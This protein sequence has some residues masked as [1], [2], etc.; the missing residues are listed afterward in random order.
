MQPAHLSRYTLSQQ[1]DLNLVRLYLQVSTLSEL[2]DE[3]NPSRIDLSYLDG[4]RSS[5]WI[6]S[7]RWPRQQQPTASQRRLWKRYLSSSYLRYIPYWRDVPSCSSVTSIVESS[8]SAPTSFST[9][10]EYITTLPRTQRRLL[11]DVEQSATDLQIWRAFRSKAKLYVASDGGLHDDRGT[12]GWILS[13][14]KHVLFRGAGPIDGPF[15][16]SSSTRSELGGCASSLLLIVVV[17]RLWGLRHRCK[18]CWFTDSKAAISRTNR[19]SRKKRATRM[20]YDADLLS[21]ISDLLAELRRPIV[22]V[23]VKGHQDSLRAYEKL[24]LAARLNIDADFLATRYRLRGRLKSSEQVDHSHGQQVSIS[25]NGK[26]LTGQFDECIRHHING[27]H[28]RQYTQEKHGWDNSTWNE[29]DFNVFARHYQR[30]RP[31]RQIQQMKLIHEQLP[32]GK[33]RY[34]QATIKDPILRLCPCCREMEEDTCHLLKCPSNP[35]HSSGLLKLGKDLHD[36]TDVHPIRHII[37]EGIRHWASG[38]PNP[39]NIDVQQFPLHM[40]ACI[41]LALESQNRIGWYPAMMGYYSR[42][43]FQVATR[44]VYNYDSND[45]QR[46]ASRMHECI[47]AVY[48]YTSSIWLSRNEILHSK[49]VDQMALIRSEEL[50]E[51]RFYHEHSHLL[52]FCDRHYCTRSLQRLLDGPP[53]TRRRWLRRV[54]KS[55]TAHQRD[56]ERQTYIPSFFRPAT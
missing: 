23:W 19:Y 46:G 48:S 52:R 12:F 2:T 26:R 49:T 27:Y 24:P 22:S 39:L 13:T 11:A 33:R 42:L 32:V 36:S 25:I 30:L 18:F 15:D 3:S 6:S 56:S 21:L 47:S 14:G 50:T 41:T 53:S 44:D 9:L 1:R 43:W 17:S 10:K 7:P 35:V 40:R 31:N 51:V 20:P 29:I 28:L 8:P 34:Q 45:T 55:F 37:T 5:E 16:S 54:K 4:Q 38:N